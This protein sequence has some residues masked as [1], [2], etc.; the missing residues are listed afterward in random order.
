MAHSAE[1]AL[2]A[3]D[4]RG[5]A[6]ATTAA[7]ASAAATAEEVLCRGE[8]SHDDRGRRRRLTLPLTPTPLGL[9]AIAQTRAS[10]EGP[11]TA[12]EDGDGTSR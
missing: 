10:I 6:I 3:P 8:A 11:S 2:A 4:R 7:A 1:K 5:T 9:A 12:S